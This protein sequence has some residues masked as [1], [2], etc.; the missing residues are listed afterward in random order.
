M[1]RPP[2]TPAQQELVA[3]NL[4][5]AGAVAKRLAN[6][7]PEWVSLDDVV[8]A[9][10][11]GLCRASQTFDPAKGAR[12]STYGWTA[13]AQHARRFL[14]EERGRGMAVPEARD[15]PAGTQ[16]FGAIGGGSDDQDFAATVV[17]PEPEPGPPDEAKV[18]AA[19]DAALPGERERLV[20]RLRF[21]DGWQLD[22]I[23]RLLGVSKERARQIEA[24]ALAGLMEQ[25]ERFEELTG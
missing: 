22:R 3:A 16:L 17:A 25:R 4:G 5:L 20:L 2:L 21:R 19:V 7:T 24:R 11:V 13:A 23:G 9:A 14:R 12:F 18:W 10:V 8:A 15:V 1:K 6:L